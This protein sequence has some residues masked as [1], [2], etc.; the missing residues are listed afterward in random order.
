MDPE[1]LFRS[2]E[3]DPD[4]VRAGAV[5]T[6]NHFGC[7]VFVE[8]AEAWRVCAADRCF[9]IAGTH[10]IRELVER[11][12]GRAQEEMSARGGR[13]KRREQVTPAH[14]PNRFGS[15]L[16]CEPCDRRAVG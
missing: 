7:F 6:G 16:P 14:T 1:L 10:R 3:S 4:D 12:L 9:R 8:M 11:L 2:S 5:C 15:K 13:A